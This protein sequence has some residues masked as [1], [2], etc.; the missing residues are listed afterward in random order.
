MKRKSLI[1]KWNQN[2]KTRYSVFENQLCNYLNATRGSHKTK[3]RH[4][5]KK[6]RNEFVHHIA[7]LI[8]QK[9]WFVWD[10]SHYAANMIFQQSGA[11]IKTIPID[12][13]GLDVDYIKTHFVKGNSLCL[14]LC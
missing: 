14:Y 1:S 12:E 4:Q 2:K 13:Q 11:I 3:K 9:M 10:L 8:R 7:T 6:Y 5:H